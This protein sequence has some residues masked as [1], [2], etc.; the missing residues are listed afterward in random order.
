V[1]QGEN[2]DPSLQRL[3][4]ITATAEGYVDVLTDA[5]DRDTDFDYDPMG[6]VSLQTLPGD[7]VVDFDYDPNG[8]LTGL[9]PPGKPIHSFE[10]NGVNLEERYI[11]PLPDPA[12]QNPDTAAIYNDAQQLEQIIRPGGDTITY[13]YDTGGRLRTI[14]HFPSGDLFT[15]NYEPTGRLENIDGPT[16]VDLDFGYLGELLASETWSGAV[17]GS[18]SRT[19]DITGRIETETVAGGETIT[20]GYDKDGL[21]TSATSTSATFTINRSQTTG[22]IDDTVLGVV[23]DTWDF[24]DFGELRSYAAD[25]GVDSLYSVDYERDKIGR[26]TQKT[27]TVGGTTTVRQC[28]YDAAGRL[29]RV[30]DGTGTQLSR[31]L[32]DDNG[33]RL[34]H[35]GTGDTLLASGNYDDQDRLKEYGDVDYSY[36]ANGELESKTESGQTTTYEY[37]AFGNL[38]TVVLPTTPATTIEYLVDGKNRRVGKK[39]DDVLVQQLFYRDQLNP[40][41]WVDDQGNLALFVYGTRTNVPDYM[42][43]DGAVYRIISDH[44]GSPILT[45]NVADGSIL[46]SIRYDEFGNAILVTG[47]WD[48]QPFGFAGG[49]YDSNTQPSV[50]VTPSSNHRPKRIRPPP[51]R[52]EPATPHDRIG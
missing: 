39:V 20:F 30:L 7:L 28:E 31:Y 5:E 29:E 25:D 23:T 3:T 52:R 18:G 8:N 43:K 17:N 45:V 34:E 41:A 19:Y 44:L 38:H 2:L 15:Y 32:Y 26:I 48:L 46:Q 51:A 14:T 49:V 47:S 22:L 1:L 42:I 40:V 6:R 21:L 10:Y 9:T 36:G 35:R 11:P 4:E 50:S 12:I 16:G 24:N 27:E 33:N 13:G 37:D